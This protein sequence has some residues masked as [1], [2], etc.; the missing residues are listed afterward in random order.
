MF[1]ATPVNHCPTVYSLVLSQSCFPPPRLLCYVPSLVPWCI[2][3]YWLLTSSVV[4]ALCPICR[5]FLSSA[6]KIRLS[7]RNHPSPQIRLGV[8]TL[9]RALYLRKRGDL[10]LTVGR[11]NRRFQCRGTGNSQVL[12][13]F[14]RHNS[15]NLF[16]FSFLLAFSL[17]VCRY[18]ASLA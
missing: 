16:Y 10:Y 8:Y 12:F 1:L 11:H 18:F 4:A 9:H 5:Q 6:N 2:F 15:A 13:F 14:H 3:E 17:T 7:R